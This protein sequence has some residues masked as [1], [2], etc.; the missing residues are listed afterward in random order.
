MDDAPSCATHHL[1]LNT[2]KSFNGFFLITIGNCFFNGANK[3]PDATQAPDV[4][5]RAALG[6]ADPFLGRSVMGHVFPFI[7]LSMNSLYIMGFNSVSPV[8]AGLYNRGLPPS[9]LRTSHG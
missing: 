7:Y 4:D 8:R 3:S 9:S 1:R 6:L 5:F 2:L